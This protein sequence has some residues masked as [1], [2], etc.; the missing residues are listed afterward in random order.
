MRILGIDPGSLTTGFGII[1]T[2]GSNHLFVTKG[3]VST[4]GEGSFPAKLRILYRGV[5]K[6]IDEF[7]P[8]QVVVESL[9][10]ATNAKSAL[11]LGHVRGVVLLAGVE[12]QLK[13][14]EYSP[15]EVKQAV[16]GYGRA[17]KMQVQKMVT[18]LLRLET[19]PEPHDVADA[20]AIAICH[21]H[22]LRFS[23]KVEASR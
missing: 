5:L 1:D 10:F 12:R 22:R 7:Q 17:D 11:K 2:D 14:F 4:R 13:V 23:E 15:L 20:L 18:T 21:A 19:E 16:V 9:F 3:I 8:E 6:V